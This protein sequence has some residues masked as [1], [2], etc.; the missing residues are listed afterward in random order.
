MGYKNLDVSIT[1]GIALVKVNRPEALNALNTNFFHE[2]DDVIADVSK[3]PEISVMIITGV[4]KAFVA[5]A[6][7]SDMVDKI[8]SAALSSWT[9]RLLLPSMVLHWVEALS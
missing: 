5:G 9:Y 3:K 7:I 4:G 8:L 6:D 1:D 2:M